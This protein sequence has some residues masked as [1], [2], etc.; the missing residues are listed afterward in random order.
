MHFYCWGGHVKITVKQSLAKIEVKGQNSDDNITFVVGFN[1]LLLLLFW[2][3]FIAVIIVVVVAAP[4]V[5]FLFVVVVAVLV[6]AQLTSHVAGGH[7]R[8]ANIALICASGVYVYIYIHV[9]N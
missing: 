2:F 4:N 3:F 9:Y 7:C 5:V 1:I 6:V 8:P